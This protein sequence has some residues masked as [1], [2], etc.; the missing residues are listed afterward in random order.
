MS[1]KLWLIEMRAPFLTASIIPVFIGAS[2]AFYST[3]LFNLLLFILTLMGAIFLHLGTNLAN[4]FYDFNNGTDKI[5]KK[6]NPFSGG[7]GLLPAG[8]MNAGS[9]HGLSIVFFALASL[10]GLYLFFILGPI[11]LVFGLIGIISGY[12]YTN[13]TVNFA[14]R[15]IGEFLVGLNFGVLLVLGTFFVQT[16]MLSLSAVF[17]SLPIA[18][19]VTGILYINQ[20]PD[21]EADKKTGKTNLVV[22]MGRKKAVTGYIFLISLVYATII[23]YVASGFLPLASLLALITIPIAMKSVKIAKKHHS[24]FPQIIPAQ[25]STIMNHLVT[26]IILIITIL[27]ST[28]L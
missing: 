5:N 3:G 16:G 4:E 9:V 19:L 14:K 1:I 26:G 8:Q 23:L 22:K 7:S 21:Y 28:L 27:I 15:G 12:F 6:R 17:V 18:F 24:A 10:I 11:I 25:S 13:T 20:F 2:Y